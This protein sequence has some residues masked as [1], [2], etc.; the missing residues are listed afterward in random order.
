MQHPWRPSS[1]IIYGGRDRHTKPVGDVWVLD[2]EDKHATW[3]KEEVGVLCQMVR[4]ASGIHN[5]K[6]FMLL[7]GGCDTKGYASTELQAYSFATPPVRADSVMKFADKDTEDPRVLEHVQGTHH[8]T[9]VNA[10]KIPER[11]AP[12]T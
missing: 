10:K 3:R 2:I 7:Y 12:W 5:K 11:I 9:D 1:L 6:K 8:N 4:R